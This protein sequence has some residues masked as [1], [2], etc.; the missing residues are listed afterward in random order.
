[1]QTSCARAPYPELTCMCD[2]CMLLQYSV[3]SLHT[4]SGNPVTAHNGSRRVHPCDCNTQV[5][6]VRAGATWQ[7]T[8][9]LQPPDPSTD[10]IRPLELYSR[11]IVYT[12]SLH[13]HHLP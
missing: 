4:H 6:L 9:A 2:V 5:R 1:M 12:S 10:F 3:Q 8:A 7:P 13:P 11:H